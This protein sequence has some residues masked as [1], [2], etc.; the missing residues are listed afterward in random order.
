MTDDEHSMAVWLAKK[1]QSMGPT[2]VVQFVDSPRDS[3]A[4]YHG[5]LG[6]MIRNEFKMWDADW[7][8]D[9]INGVDVSPDHPDQ[10]SQRIIEYCWDRLQDG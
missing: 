5:S 7:R 3:L 9:I 10:R 4:K 6:R 1:I 8:P 2:F